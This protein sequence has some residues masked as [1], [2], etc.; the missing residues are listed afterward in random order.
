MSEFDVLLDRLAERMAPVVAELV[1]DRIGAAASESPWLD[2]PA[3]C[4]YLGM[5]RDALYKLTA[6]KPAPA[7]PLHRV[8]TRILFKRDEL[9]AWLDE[10]YEGPPRSSAQLRA[11]G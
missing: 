9:D 1:V 3:A 7:I 6:A 4:A 11:V 2:V 8:G 10:H 5:T